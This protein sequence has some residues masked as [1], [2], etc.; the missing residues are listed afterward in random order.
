MASGSP[1]M[2][3]LFHQSRLSPGFPYFFHPDLCPMV[4]L[5]FLARLSPLL[6]V[7]SLPQ[8]R[9][10]PVFSQTRAPVLLFFLLFF[11]IFLLA[12][13]YFFVFPPRQLFKRMAFVHLLGFDPPWEDCKKPTPLPTAA[14]RTLAR[15]PQNWAHFTNW[16]SWSCPNI[17][18]PES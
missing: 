3:S 1:I 6:A 2:L 4:S 12:L 15:H 10:P 9:R 18:T 14:L 13:A 16:L 7:G 11:Q 5:F 17:Q 8:K